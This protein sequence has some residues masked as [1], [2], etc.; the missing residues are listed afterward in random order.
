MRLR[1]VMPRSVKG[2]KR[3]SVDTTTN[4]T[5]SVGVQYG[6]FRIPMKTTAGT[7]LLLFQVVM[8][9]YARFVPSRYF[10][11][12]PF[13]IQTEYKLQVEVDGRALSAKEVRARYRRQQNGTDNRSP[14]HVMDIV[15]GYEETYGRSNPARV[16]MRY[17]VNGKQEQVWRWPRQ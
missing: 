11:W 5:H 8:I 6:K 16:E 10:C 9:V 14:Q 12:A 7:A 15:Q 1:M 13:D 4:L 3:E 17:R 2:E